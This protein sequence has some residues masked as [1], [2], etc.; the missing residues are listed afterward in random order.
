MENLARTD[1]EVAE[2]I[3]DETRAARPPARDDRLRELRLRGGA[4]GAR[5]RRSRTSTPRAI[6]GKRYYGGCEFVDVAES[7]AIERAKQLFGADHANVQPHSGAQANM[8]VYMAAVKPGDTILGMNLSHGGH[9]THGHPLN[10]SGQATSR[11]SPTACAR[12]T[13]ASTTTDL[14]RLALEHRPKLIVVGASAYPRIDR[15]RGGPPGRRRLGRA[16]DGRH[17]PH[18]GPGGG[19]P[20]PLARPALRVRDHDHAQD[21][22]RPA[23]RHDPLPA[24]SGRRRSTSAL[25]PG[26]QGGPLMHVIAAKAVAFKEA[27][28]AGVQGLSEADR[29][30]R[31]G[32][33]GGA[34]RRGLPPRLRRHRQPPDAG[35]RVREGPHGQG[36]REGARP[37]RHHRQ[38]EHDPV[39]HE[40]ADGRL[41][42]PRSARRRSPRAA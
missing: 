21:A 32:A 8:A 22:A 18:R 1:P 19:G 38:Q 15:L 10:F 12:R 6:P 23:R 7:L 3:R 24:R 40:L 20:A 39:R 13:S 37:G 26:V 30:E 14:Q 36:R 28:D 41:R 29:R 17:R 4:R 25:F 9:L 33:R 42:H 11:S 16:R 2:A 34:D 35:R 5:H 27:L 31:G